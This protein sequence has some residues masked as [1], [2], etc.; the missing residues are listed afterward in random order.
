M[1]GFAG[2]SGHDGFL[3]GGFRVTDRGVHADDFIGNIAMHDGA[4]AVAIIACPAVFRE[5][6]HDDRLARPEF[7]GTQIMTVRRRTVH[8]Q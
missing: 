5:D 1:H 4:G 7:S 6:V 8:R 3:G 2:D